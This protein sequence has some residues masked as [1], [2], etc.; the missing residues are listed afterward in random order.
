MDVLVFGGQSNMQGQ[1]EGLPAVNP[2]IRDAEN[3]PFSAFFVPFLT[4][5]S[6]FEVK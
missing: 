5:F 4:I 2:V 3:V 1:T 6:D